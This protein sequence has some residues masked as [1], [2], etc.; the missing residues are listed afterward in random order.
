MQYI[1][2]KN[3]VHRDLAARNI[4]LTKDFNAKISDF[5]LSMCKDDESWSPEKWPIKW[6]SPEA[7]YFHTF[8]E[9]SDVWSFGVLMYEVFSFGKVPYEN[10]EST[11][12]ILNYLLSGRRLEC[13]KAAKKGTPEIMSSCWMMNPHERPTFEDLIDCFKDILNRR[14]IH[15]G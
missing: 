11:E 8:S 7:I 13:P 6:M 15:E 1:A 10:L 5:G 12:E 3:I 4:L 9:K 2:S 14:N